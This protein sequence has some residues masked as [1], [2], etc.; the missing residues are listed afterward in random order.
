M[1][2]FLSFSKD[3]CWIAHMRTRSHMEIEKKAKEMLRKGEAWKRPRKSD[4]KQW[5]K[6][7][8][9]AFALCTPIEESS[10]G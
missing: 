9:D 8:K 6:A 3:E 2:T 7:C 4:W 10:S 1:D 5:E